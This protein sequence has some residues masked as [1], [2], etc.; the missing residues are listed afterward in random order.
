M[1]PSA[2]SKNGGKKKDAP[3]KPT[4]NAKPMPPS[5][6]RSSPMK[7]RRSMESIK[8]SKPKEPGWY[9]RAALY[10]G[11]L[12]AFQITTSDFGNDA[13]T[14]PLI[15]KLATDDQDD[16]NQI[17]LLGAYYMRVSVSN[18]AA[19]L[20]SKNGYQRKAF[21]CVLEEN[22]CNAESLLS[23]VETIKR[24]L[25]KP[26]NNRFGTKVFIQEPGWDLTPPDPAPLPKLDHILQ[27]RHIAT[28]IRILF[29][30]VDSTWA[31]NHRDSA[32]LF[33]TQGHIPYE[34]AADIGFPPDA[35]MPVEPG[36]NN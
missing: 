7:G 6:N 34:A 33:F 27:Y 10:S 17:G 16:I 35:V 31:V 30:N 12:A 5:P 21:L 26:E 18:P 15:E 23:K 4:G 11:N 28:V 19:L 3:T 22:E 9:L 1:G 13:F 14:Q 29:D 2:N 20:N 36:I 24:F 32:D 8:Q 25:E